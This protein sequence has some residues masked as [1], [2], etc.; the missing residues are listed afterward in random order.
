MATA[1]T[2]VNY[3]TIGLDFTACHPSFQAVREQYQILEDVMAGE[4]AVKQKRTVY[5]PMPNPTDQSAGNLTRYDQY[6]TRAIFPNITRRMA[7]TLVGLGFLREPKMELPKELEVLKDDC[8]GSGLSLIQ[9]AKKMALETIVYG[10][11]GVLVDYPSRRLAMS[12]MFDQMRVRPYLDFYKASEITNW[13]E[14]GYRLQFVTLTRAVELL[15]SY[16]VRYEPCWRLLEMK[17]GNR[18]DFSSGGRYISRINIMT[19]GQTT[20]MPVDAMG[21]PFDHI[22][23]HICGAFDNAWEIRDNDAPL[24]PVATLNLG[25]YRNIADAEEIAFIA[26]Q[27]QIF[28]RGLDNTQVRETEDQDVLVGAR[29]GIALGPN[30]NAQLL[31]ASPN[32]APRELA[33]D[34][35][36]MMQQLGV[37]LAVGSS[38]IMT[39]TEVVT[40]SL[41]RN[42]VLTSVLQ[43]VGVSLTNALK[44][45]CMYVGANPESVMFEVDTSV[46]LTEGQAQQAV[47]ESITRGDSMGN[48][49]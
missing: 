49:R 2:N 46:E 41:I 25:L 36:E 18:E 15:Q 21:K 33:L 9:L 14:Q 4:Q 11:C 42:S 20:M 35:V 40:E 47:S 5:L 44:D 26:G 34:K 3:S 23:F 16:V 8:N 12:K 48:E 45:A 19:D 31:Q 29:V 28:V 17:G 43:N 7:R 38:N 13:Y 39:A 37:Q 24:Y 32:N 30:G 6:L 27:P 10:R 1:Q 22:T